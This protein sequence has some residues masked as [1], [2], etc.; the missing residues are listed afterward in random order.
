MK[1]SACGCGEFKSM[2]SAS[3]WATIEAP[4]G[5]FRSS[6][7]N[8]PRPANVAEAVSAPKFA[9]TRFP[10]TVPASTTDFR[11]AGLLTSARRPRPARAHQWIAIKRAAL[12]AMLEA[13]G[14]FRRQQGRQ[15][16]A[17]ADALAERHDVGRDPHARNGTAFAVR[18]MPVWISSKISSRPCSLVSARNSRRN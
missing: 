5:C 12:V 10:E 7:S 2:P 9:V 18:P 6:A 16:H 4:I 17:A 15:R 13:G 14:R 11:N 3:A 1:R 8:R